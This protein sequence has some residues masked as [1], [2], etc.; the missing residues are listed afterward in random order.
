M[1]SS[2]DKEYLDR[3]VPRIGFPLEKE[4]LY[5]YNL[6][7]ER[8]NLPDRLEPNDIRVITGLPEVPAPKPFP[9]SLLEKYGLGEPPTLGSS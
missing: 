8:E 5:T 9:F 6:T 7:A 1:L 2:V 4:L 3:Q